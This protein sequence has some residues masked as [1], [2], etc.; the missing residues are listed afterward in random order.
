M[1][2][3]I[4]FVGNSERALADPALHTSVRRAMVRFRELQR[5]VIDEIDDWQALR[6]YAHRV[7][8]HTLSHLDHYLE[9]LEHQIVAAGGQVHW[10]RDGAHAGRVIAD[11]ARSR[12]DR[13]VVKSKSMTSEEIDLNQVLEAA[14]CEVV[15]TDLGEYLL[16]LAGDR[17][18]HIIAPAVHKSKEAIAKLLADKLGVPVYDDAERLTRVAR[19]AL[20]KKFLTAGIGITG[21]NFAVAET[22]TIVVVENEGNARLT[23]SLS[24]VHIALMGIEKVIPRLAD[25]GVFLTLLPRAATGQRMSSYVS[26]LTGPRRAGERD[27][28]E[29]FHLVIMDNGRTAIQADPVMR[30]S[31]AC[32]RCGACLDVCPVFERTVGHAYGSV[33][34]GPIG[35][36]IT[37]LYQGLDVAG[38]L[39]FA[40]SLCGACGEI[41]PVKID[42]PRLLLELRA[43]VVQ[44]AVEA[45]DSIFAGKD[46]A[47]LV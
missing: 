5:G 45:P 28:P 35:A 31:L 16:Q 2:Q 27:G 26:L 42:L 7:K 24:R 36:V 39:P 40:S 46:A 23:T 29:E 34:S 30:E 41:C 17:P 32:I 13:T 18:A 21:V 10:V 3:R 1:N 22:G 47:G 38:E 4:D 33:Y 12:D 6:E 37:P 43:R 44:A 25:L 19:D 14:G 8:L 20:R 9:Q 11:L 15:E